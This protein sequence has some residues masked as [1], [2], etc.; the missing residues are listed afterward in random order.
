M[1][2]N[3]LIHTIRLKK[4][5][6]TYNSLH[7][8]TRKICRRATNIVQQKQSNIEK[9]QNEVKI[10]KLWFWDYNWHLFINKTV[11]FYLGLQKWNCISVVLKGLAPTWVQIYYFHLPMFPS[12][13][14][15]ILSITMVEVQFI[16]LFVFN[17]FLLVFPGAITDEKQERKIASY[18][19][20]SFEIIEMFDSV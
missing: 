14:Y 18:S 4:E 19:S 5:Y 13:I 1:L 6:K 15:Q 3:K 8:W 20:F 16:T 9:R 12:L 11:L 10:N 17:M 2:R 7:T